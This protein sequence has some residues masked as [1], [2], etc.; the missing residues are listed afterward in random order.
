MRVLDQERGINLTEQSLQAHEGAISSFIDNR[1]FL[2]SVVQ[3]AESYRI[4]VYT[5][6]SN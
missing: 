2:C 3:V 1:E 6:Y 4:Y 5:L